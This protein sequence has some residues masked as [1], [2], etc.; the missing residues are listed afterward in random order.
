LVA[1][2]LDRVGLA[3]FSSDPRAPKMAWEV[4]RR[5]VVNPKQARALLEAVRAQQPSG[6]RLVAFFGVLY[7]SGLRPEEAI[8]L[9][10][11][12]VVIPDVADNSGALSGGDPGSQW[13][14]LH[15]RKA[16]PDVGK[17]WT[18]DGCGRDDRGLKHRAEGESRP[19]PC[20]LPSPDC[21]GSILPNSAV[22]PR[23]RC[24][25]GCMADLWPPSHTV[26]HGTAPVRQRCRTRNIAR[27]LL[28][29]H[30][31]FATHAS[32]PG[33]TGE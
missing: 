25:G 30:T 31:T 15:L 1:P 28:A 2:P 23:T 22:N 20:P 3:S 21:S 4:D 18:D 33:S 5:V 7:Y 10:H 24:S 19:V 32:L 13:G 16:K 6:P 29:V 9:R 8:G 12:D 17:R 26:A 27:R 14:E 11:R